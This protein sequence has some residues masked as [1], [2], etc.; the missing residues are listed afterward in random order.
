[1]CRY[2]A[3]CVEYLQGMCMDDTAHVL[4]AKTPGMLAPHRT[5]WGL[6]VH[7]EST[8]S[9]FLVGFSIKLP[10]LVYNHPP[11]NSCQRSNSQFGLSSFST[12]PRYPPPFIAFVK[13]TRLLK[14]L[15]L[16][17]RRGAG[18]GAGAGAGRAAGG[19]LA[20]LPDSS[21]PSES[22]LAL[23]PRG[24]PSRLSP[25]FLRSALCGLTSDII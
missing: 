25:A 14:G 5:F 18:A 2:Y 9:N 16:R 21:R 3:A 4:H 13:A 20:L 7:C 1:M 10:L 15:K 19:L 23:S 8:R 24:L 22:F 6:S 11:I 12:V 17:S